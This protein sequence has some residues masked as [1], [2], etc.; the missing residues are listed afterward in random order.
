MIPLPEI[1]RGAGQY[2]VP[3]ET[4]EKDY[5]ICWILKCLSTSKLREDFIFYEGS[6]FWL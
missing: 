4:V 6:A 2:K 1:N 3:A 5:A